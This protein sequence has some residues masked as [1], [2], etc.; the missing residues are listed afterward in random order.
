MRNEVNGSLFLNQ[1]GYVNKI[2]KRFNMFDC[3]HVTLSLTNHFNLSS[4]FHPKT[5]DESHRM[6]KIPFANAIGYL[7]YLMICTRPNL[8][9]SIIVL[10]RFM[11][12]PSESH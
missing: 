12:N 2:L 4:D 6:F 9:Y 11:G 7:M 8:A 10:S 1:Q 3:K 5:K